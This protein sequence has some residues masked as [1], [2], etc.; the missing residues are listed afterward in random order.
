MQANAFVLAALLLYVIFGAALVIVFRGIRGI[1]AAIVIGW[2]FLP[3]V[4]GIDLPGIPV[5]TKEYA[6]SYAILLGVILSDSA[7]LMSFKPKLIDLPILIYILVPFFSSITNGLGAYDGMSGIYAKFFIFGVPY[8]LG[9]I[10]IKNPNDVKIV[11]KW[12]LYAGL[13]AIPMIVWESKMSPQLNKQIYGYQAS[14]FNMTQR[15]GGYRPMMFMRHG[16][17][18]GLWIATSGAVAL[19]LWITSAKKFRLF[20]LPI[21]PFTS[22]IL[23]ATVLSRSL[24]AIFLLAGTTAVA[25]FV[26]STGFRIALIALI[27]TP[28]IYLSVRI[29]NIWTPSQFTAIIASIDAER[30]SSLQARLDQEV[31]FSKHAL[32]KPIFGWGGYNRFRPVNDDGGSDAVDGLTTIVLGSNGL[33][34]LLAY[35]GMTTLPSLLVI[36]RIKGRAITSA[37]WA[38]GVGIILAISILAMDMLLNS[39]YTPLHLIG[40]GVIASIA[41]QAKQWQ[42]IMQ[43]HQNQIRPPT[44]PN[45]Y[46]A[47]PSPP[48][49]V[50]PIMYP[51]RSA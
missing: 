13:I 11:A 35:L 32:R 46:K 48:E 49:P 23:A 28:S 15:L 34:G 38:P 29:S 19:W 14:P 12:F 21:A 33:V 18:V 50:I 1:M 51:P 36:H 24:G 37:L 43:T 2:L 16:L 3:P 17:E 39:F 47:E 5:F 44:P 6:V 25:V 7:K 20:N 8:L 22:A 40:I 10:F 9:R 31:N 26:R 4:K 45:G 30:A 41:V 27:L 42:Q